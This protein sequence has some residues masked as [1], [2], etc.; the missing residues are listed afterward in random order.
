MPNKLSLL[1]SK[2]LLGYRTNY[3]DDFLTFLEISGETKN[4]NYGDEFLKITFF[5]G[6]G[7]S[8]FRHDNMH[9]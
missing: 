8:F 5:R 6:G 7:Y 4:T 2:S 1:F 9:H 3:G